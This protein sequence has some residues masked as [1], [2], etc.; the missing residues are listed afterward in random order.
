MGK[1]C[2]I[3]DRKFFIRAAIEGYANEM[4]F[5][6]EQAEKLEEELDRKEDLFD[7]ITG[8]V[9]KVNIMR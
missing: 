4:E 1:V 9:R 6:E 3:C 5:Y 2:K 7:N 8:Q